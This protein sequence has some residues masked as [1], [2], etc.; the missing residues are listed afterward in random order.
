MHNE[1]RWGD[2]RARRLPNCRLR[3][4][5]L[6]EG[7]PEGEFWRGRQKISSRSL[8]TDAGS[9]GVWAFSQR[10]SIYFKFHSRVWN[11]I[12]FELQEIAAN[13]PISE[14]YS[15]QGPYPWVRIK[16]SAIPALLQDDKDSKNFISVHPRTSSGTKRKLIIIYLR[17]WRTWPRDAGPRLLGHP[18]GLSCRRRYLSDPAIPVVSLSQ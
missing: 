6:R 15:L 16:T 13:L 14:A 9:Y 5:R 7:L 18:S 4:R 11:K 17:C 2:V 3:C 8:R 1:W 10:I 12:P